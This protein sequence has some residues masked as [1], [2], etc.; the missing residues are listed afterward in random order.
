MKKKSLDEI[1][2][3]VNDRMNKEYGGTT[4][5]EVLSNKKKDDPALINEVHKKVRINLIG[6]D[7]TSF[8]LIKQFTKSAKRQGWTRTEISFVVNKCTLSD[9]KHLVGTLLDYTEEVHDMHDDDFDTEE[10]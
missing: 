9:Y 8:N 3:Q 5:K 6:L 10:E 2:Q 4:L 1:K 7:L